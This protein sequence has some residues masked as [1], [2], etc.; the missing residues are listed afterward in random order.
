MSVASTT[1]RRSAST[2]FFPIRVLGA[3]AGL[4]LML[5]SL[6]VPSHA[7]TS[8]TVVMRAN[9]FFP[10]ELHVDPGDEV[11]WT[12]QD[13]R[14]VHDVVSDD[15]LFE[16]GDMRTGDTFARTFNK[17]GY[18]YYHCFYHGARGQVGMW[19]VVIVGDPPP[20][21]TGGT[22]DK[23]PTL[24]VPKDYK[25]IQKAVDHARPGTTILVSPGIYRE[26][27]VVNTK[28]VTIEGVDRFRTIL[29]GGNTR[30]N[31]VVTIGVPGLRVKNMTI[32]RYVG[33]GVSV[34]DASR[35]LVKQVDA[36]KNRT[37]GIYADSSY[38]GVIRDSFLW[39]SG[40][41]GIHVSSC[42]ECS[43]L[44]DGV[45]SQVN[46]TGYLGVNATGVVIRDSR[47]KGNG[48]GIVSAT[49]PDDAQAPGRGTTM[50]GNIVAGNNYTTIPSAGFSSDYDIPFGTGI[51][52]LG[53]RN[54]V[55]SENVVKSHER[56]GILVSRTSGDLPAMNNSVRDNEIHFSGQY[57]LAWDGAGENNCFSSNV[58][59]TSG[60]GDIQ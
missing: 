27:V 28:N 33:A 31:G 2:A 20:P 3:L 34:H 26:E 30:G 5:S 42:L 11:V 55:A 22:P 1:T 4:L 59:E 52:L 54:N 21:G 16:S 24:K 41:S 29:D 18:F 36:I 49:L 12:H 43:T 17:E 8:Q 48:V 40:D 25:S 37:Y 19:G 9:T 15:D 35:Y 60:P 58:F 51:W 13:G 50:L 57:D 44:V 14:A 39:G 6:A 45:T 53:V 32:R 7:A 47:F 38:D 46:Y 10:Q 56:Y 23:R